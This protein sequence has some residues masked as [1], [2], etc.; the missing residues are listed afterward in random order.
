MAGGSLGVLAVAG[1]LSPTPDDRSF[2][3]ALVILLAF[4]GLVVAAGSWA[5]SWVVRLWGRFAERDVVIA[6]GGVRVFRGPTTHY[7]ASRLVSGM[8]IPRD[9]GAE[10]RLVL[11]GGD[12]LRLQVPTVHAANDALEAL[13]LA[14]GDKRLAIRWGVSDFPC[15]GPARQFIRAVAPRSRSRTG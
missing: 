12:T 9:E 3:W 11:E 15:T 5:S 6:E 8:V 2:V 13:D 14:P 7:P 1:G 4:G 10:L